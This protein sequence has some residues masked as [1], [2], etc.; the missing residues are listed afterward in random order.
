M[1]DDE[2]EQD[3][4][5]DNHTQYRLIE[6][7]LQVI[8]YNGESLLQFKPQKGH[9]TMGLVRKANVARANIVAAEKMVELKG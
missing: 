8:L 4:F 5:I 3:K 1:K 7:E 6:K 2:E 9:R